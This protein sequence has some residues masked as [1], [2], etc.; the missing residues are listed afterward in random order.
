MKKPT[1]TINEYDFQGRRHG[2]WE[3]YWE[4]GILHRRLYYRYGKLHGV[5]KQ[6]L[7]D[8]KPQWKHYHLNIR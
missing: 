5:C 2:A 7:Q 3:S 6:Y 4:G 8:G 1:Y